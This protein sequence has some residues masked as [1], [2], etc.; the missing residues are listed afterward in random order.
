M[1]FPESFVVL[2][3]VG[4]LNSNE[5]KDVLYDGKALEF[6][7]QGCSYSVAQDGLFL[8]YSLYEGRV[9][10]QSTLLEYG[11]L[12]LVRHHDVQPFAQVR[13]LRMF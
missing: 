11:Q 2:H 1:N 3:A 10:S 9:V 12:L 6:S 13:L 8:S 4:D 5:W 7:C